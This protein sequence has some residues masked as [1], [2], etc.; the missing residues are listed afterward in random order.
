MFLRF[1]F[2]NGLNITTMVQVFKFSATAGTAH[3]IA[4]VPFFTIDVVVGTTER[5]F[6]P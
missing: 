3:V 5:T 1:F 6:L 4:F 2:N